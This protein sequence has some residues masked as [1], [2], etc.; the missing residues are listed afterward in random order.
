MCS[1]GGAFS[2]TERCLLHNDAQEL[3]QTAQWHQGQIDA[4]TPVTTWLVKPFP[5]AAVKPR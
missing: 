2:S 5:V 3:A 4:L 1:A